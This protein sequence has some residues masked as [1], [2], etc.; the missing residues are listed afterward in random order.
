[1]VR[2]QPGPA[3]AKSNLGRRLLDNL[4]QV[5]RLDSRGMLELV[6]GFDRQLEQAL[7]TARSLEVKRSDPIRSIVICGMGGSA[8]S[9]DL[10]KACVDSQLSVPVQVIRGYSVPAHVD[11]TTLALVC[12]Y[13]GNTEETLSAWEECRQRGACIICM[14]SGGKLENLAREN[15]QMCVEIPPGLPPRTTFAYS[16]VP[17]FRILSRLGL[18]PDYLVKV[19]QSLAWVKTKIAAFGSIVPVQENAA[20]RL[21]LDLWERIPVVYASQGRLEGIGRRWISQF[22]ENGKQL[23]FLNLLPEMNHNEIVGWMHPKEELQRFLPIFLRDRE[24]HPRIQIRA[25]LTRDFLQ[26]KAGKALEFWS[27]GES[28]LERLCALLLLGDF[29]SVY[30]A[31]LN[32]EDPTPVAPIETFKNRLEQYS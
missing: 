21:A 18:A 17:M 22:A 12:S 13:S 24:D 14:A 25:E 26:E 8:I 10:L 32:Q 27:D 6:S 31:L 16:L 7:K 1:M 15:Q 28:W 2:K 9:G 29:T 23:G 11:S 5:G 30:L 19:E 4:Q 20:K 3:G